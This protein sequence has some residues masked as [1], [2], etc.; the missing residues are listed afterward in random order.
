[1]TQ[2]ALRPSIWRPRVLVRGIVLIVTLAALGLLFEG[3][4]LKHLLEQGWID[5]HIRGQG[6]TGEA[7]FV[8]VGALFTAVGLPRQ[9]VAFL[10]GYA[11]GIVIGTG[12]ALLATVTGAVGVFFYARFMARSFLARKFPDKVSKLDSF[13]ADNTLGM[14][15][16]LRLAPFTHNLTTNLVAGVSGVR[17]L[18]FF[19]GSALGYLPQTIV[20][21]LLGG[22]IELDPVISTA[23]SVVLFAVST[24]LG[25][26]LWRRYRKDRDEG[27]VS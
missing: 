27:D 23:V 10:A 20:F 22:G 11:F 3:L 4:G 19:A 13:L 12:L 6:L 2:A 16:V 1:M 17:P 24:V 14:A 18:P 15:L 8:V 26:L 7:L 9:V 25:L 5:E 21:A